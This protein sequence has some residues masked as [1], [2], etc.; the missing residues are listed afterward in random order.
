LP[1]LFRIRALENRTLMG[2]ETYQINHAAD[3]SGDFYQPPGIF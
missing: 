3:A 2:V 1:Y